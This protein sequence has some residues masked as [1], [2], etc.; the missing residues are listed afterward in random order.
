MTEPEDDDSVFTDE[1][2]G[3][4][5]PHSGASTPGPLQF[6]IRPKKQ[7]RRLV[8][9]QP[10]PHCEKPVGPTFEACPHCGGK[11]EVREARLKTAPTEHAPHVPEPL[12]RELA[13]STQADTRRR[14]AWRRVRT[15]NR[16]LWFASAIPFMA[17]PL[18]AAS[19]LVLSG[20][21]LLLFAVID[22][23]FAALLAYVLSRRPDAR[24]LAPVLLFPWLLLHFAAAKEPLGFVVFASGALL[25]SLA[26]MVI[27]MSTELV[28]D[29]IRR[30]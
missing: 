20:K 9:T 29:E 3:A 1:V 27:G 12:A 5:L 25:S 17:G 8:V 16:R 15:K 2:G 21:M 7:E 30:D 18:F 24:M 14:A 13:V 10:C 4:P 19:Y 6:R 28:H 26:F 23:A 22:V 11:I